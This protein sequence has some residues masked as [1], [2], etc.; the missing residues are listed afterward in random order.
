MTAGSELVGTWRLKSY[1]ELD[2][3]GSVVDEPFGRTPVGKLVYTG[4]WHMSVLLMRA[5]RAA[6]EVPF[7]RYATTEQ[8]S[9]T[10]DGYLGYCGTYRVEDDLVIHQVEISSFPDWVGLEQRREMELDHGQLVLRS[11]PYVWCGE[12]RTPVLTWFRC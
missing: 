7:P 2:S 5:D 4:D 3:A 9:S 11:T 8:K 10:V 1:Q 6:L 12:E